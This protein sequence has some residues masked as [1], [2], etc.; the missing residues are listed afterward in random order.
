MA[1]PRVAVQ[2]G[3]AARA[4]REV[5]RP[6]SLLIVSTGLGAAP[7]SL[8]LAR[9]AA[10]VLA[11]DGIPADLLDLRELEFPFGG[12]AGSS[13]DPNV[14]RG[15]D[16]VSAANGIILSTPVY[17]YDANAVAKNFI[18]LTGQGW[19]NKVVGFLCCAGGDKSFMSIMPLANS[20]MLDFRCVIVPRFVYAT[21]AAFSGDKIVD[22][23]IAARI[24]QCA[25]AT[26]Q[27]AA[28]VK[29]LR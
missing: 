27:L 2:Q 10:R 18:E 8:V 21:G 5:T 4:G 11:A 22:A 20:L 24:A 12:T 9:E 6:V 13:A 3:P 16:H 19:E 14:G 17:N 26:A 29:G 7:K 28:A 15:L 25:H 1:V 23:D